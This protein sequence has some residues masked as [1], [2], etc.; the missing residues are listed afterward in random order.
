M[1][2][3]QIITKLTLISV[4]IKSYAECGHFMVEQSFLVP[5][6]DANYPLAVPSSYKCFNKICP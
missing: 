1:F 3:A 5:L 4:S 2:Q 6:W